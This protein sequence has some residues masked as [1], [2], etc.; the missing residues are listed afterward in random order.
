MPC[1][2]VL[3]LNLGD[4]RCQIEKACEFIGDKKTQKSVQRPKIA[5]Y[6]HGL[7]SVSCPIAPPPRGGAAIF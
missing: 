4:L 7:F 5:C 6:H 1:L 3:L 2:F